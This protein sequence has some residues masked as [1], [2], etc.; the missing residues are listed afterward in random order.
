MQCIILYVNLTG[1]G[2]AQVAGKI[3]FLDP[4]VRIFPEEIRI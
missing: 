4:C 2:D 3:L 1:Q